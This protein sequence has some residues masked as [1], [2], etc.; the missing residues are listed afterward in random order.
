MTPIDADSFLWQSVE[1]T[2]DGEPLPDLPPVKV[3]RVKVK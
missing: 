2:L 3:V 1:R